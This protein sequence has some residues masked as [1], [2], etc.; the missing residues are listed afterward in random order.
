MLNLLAR[1]PNIIETKSLARYNF[2][3]RFSDLGWISKPD[4]KNL[5][6]Y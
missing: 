6:G 3:A 4:I 5:A 2:L 1:Y